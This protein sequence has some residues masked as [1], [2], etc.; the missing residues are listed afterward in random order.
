MSKLD[1]WKSDTFG[2]E[3][4]FDAF[5]G[6]EYLALCLNQRADWECVVPAILEHRDTLRRL[7]LHCIDYNTVDGVVP[8]RRDRTLLWDEVARE[9]YQSCDLDFI[10]SSC[11][12]VTEAVWTLG[13][14]WPC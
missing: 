5:T 13:S 3:E 11:C 6:L 10:V 9:L 12:D 14:S 2:L 8:P 4:F 7:I 1:D